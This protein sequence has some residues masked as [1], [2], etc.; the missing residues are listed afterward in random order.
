MLSQVSSKGNGGLDVLLLRG[1][2]AA[3]EQDDEFA[4]PLRVVDAVPGSEVDLQFSDATGEVAMLPRV[5]MSQAVD[6][7]LNARSARPVLQS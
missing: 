6:A 5:S 7:D 3:S 2:V 4:S 1:F